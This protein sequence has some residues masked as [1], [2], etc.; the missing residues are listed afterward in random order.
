M[1]AGAS[2]AVSTFK[3]SLDIGSDCGNDELLLRLRGKKTK[4]A[5]NIEKESLGFETFDK[6][7]ALHFPYQAIRSWTTADNYFEIHL[8]SIDEPLPNETVQKIR[9]LTN[10]ASDIAS[11]LLKRIHGLM[12]EMEAKALKK[13]S[14]EAICALIVIKEDQN[15]EDE[16]QTVSLKP[17]WK[18]IADNYLH[19]CEGSFT[20]SQAIE[21]MGLSAFDRI[22]TAA[23][24]RNRM[25]NPESFVIVVNALDPADK[26]NLAHLLSVP[27]KELV[28]NTGADSATTLTC[29]SE[30]SNL[31]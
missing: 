25:L 9:V 18:T 27:V 22:E 21:L 6:S 12:S 23:Y 4:F 16:S 3:V 15:E 29:P 5:L 13:S 19:S 7:G 1:G 11:T 10:E 31:R 8:G 14:F 24:L 28:G 2:V 26:E 20:S 17:D 30:P